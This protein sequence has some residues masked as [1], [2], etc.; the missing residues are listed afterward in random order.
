MNTALAPIL[1]AASL[2][3]IMVLIAWALI[4]KRNM[5]HARF[6]KPDGMRRV[7]EIGAGMRIAIV[8]ID[9]Q[10]VACAIGKTGV[11]AM[12]VLRDADKVAET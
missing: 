5:L 7:I 1:S 12:Q 2:I 8:E 6:G 9:G 11:T 4:R 10:R 3:A